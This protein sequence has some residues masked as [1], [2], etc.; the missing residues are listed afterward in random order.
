MKYEEGRIIKEN[1]L[2]ILGVFSDTPKKDIVANLGKL[3]AFVK[4]GKALSFD[5][6]FTSLL[7][8]VNRTSNT[9]EKAN[10]DISLPKDKLQAGMFWFMQHT[11]NDKAALNCLKSGDVN[12]AMAII[13][14]KGNYSSTVNMGVLALILKRWD[15]A[16]YSY[17]FLL[18]S[19]YRR[20]AL[21]K[22][23]IDTE[24]SISENDLVEYISSKLIQEFPNVHWIEQLQQD[25]I[26]LENNLHPFKSRFVGSKLFEQLTDKCINKVKN[27]LESTLKKGSSISREDAKAN[28]EYVEG[29][30]DQLKELLKDLRLALG[31]SNGIY[32][33][34]ADKVANQFL[35]CCINYY[36]NDKT[37]PNRARVILKYTRIAYRFAEGE[38]AKDRMKANLE[39]IEQACEDLIPE[40]IEKEFDAIDKM[41]M[42]YH[43]VSKTKDYTEHLGILIEDAYKLIQIIKDKI[44]RTNKHYIDTSSNFVLFAIQEVR[45]KKK[46]TST[47]T[48]SSGRFQYASALQWGRQILDLLAKFDKDDK[49]QLEYDIIFTQVID[50]LNSMK[51]SNISTQKT[52]NNSSSTLKTKPAQTPPKSSSKSTQTTQSN[53]STTGSY[54]YSA[55]KVK[56]KID[57]SED[58][59]LMKYILI[60]MIII[61]IV[62]MIILLGRSCKNSNTSIPQT[63]VDSPIVINNQKELENAIISSNNNVRTTSSS[64]LNNRI[65]SSTQLTDSYSDNNLSSVN[66]NKSHQEETFRTI[67]YKTGERPYQST[68]GRG[69]YDSETQNSLLIRNG[70]ST[71]A[72]VFLERTNGKKVRHVYIERGQNFTMT[73]IPGGEYIIKVMQGTDWNPEKDN[74]SGNPKGG[75]MYSCSIS[76]SESY[77]AFDY[78][79]PSSGQY[80][81]YEVTLYK[82]QNGNMQTEVINENEL[83]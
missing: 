10:N 18:D 20:G 48:T 75:F 67:Q 41:V 44:G 39:I 68:Y 24:D 78:P 36:N 28:L 83:F 76:R 13:Q 66:T 33:K 62:V 15:L 69:N 35:N 58:D 65:N 49:C 19:D 40:L 42:D 11:D 55:E 79:Y 72:V 81:Q 21:I 38:T 26:E 12:G 60:I 2:R 80:G 34:Y 4:T 47:Y 14:K 59:G 45:L 64:S 61:F 82:V 37:N 7:G 6:D 32:I 63:E 70:S 43:E 57:S 53:R 17:A 77:D 51:P 54:R 50:G 22:S 30:K 56:E 23:F 8:P 27:E 5:S 29:A 25:K 73:K 31:K 3:R 46:A 52:I 71:D 74:G 1:P 9:I 16:L